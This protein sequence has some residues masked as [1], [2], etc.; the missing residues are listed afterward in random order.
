MVGLDPTIHAHCV[1]PVF[2]GPR[3]KSEDDGG[4]V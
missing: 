4:E 2:M 1:S 3:I